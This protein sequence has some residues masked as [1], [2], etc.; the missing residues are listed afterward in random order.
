MSELDLK[1]CPFCGGHAHIMKMGYPHWVI[2]TQCGAK[3]HGGKFG[4]KEGE[5]A[6]IAAWNR[7]TSYSCDHEKDHNADSSKMVCVDAISRQETIH[8]ISDWIYDATDER[9]PETVIRSL[10]AVQPE[11]HWIPCSERL[12]GQSGEYLVT[13]RVGYLPGRVIVDIA[14]YIVDVG[15]WK[16]MYKVIAWMPLPE[17]YKGGDSE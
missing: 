11:P 14:R 5:A 9:L 15:E 10:S 17:P 1:P 16:N 7:R 2:C 3:V 6:S 8:A 13:L 4:E 12:P